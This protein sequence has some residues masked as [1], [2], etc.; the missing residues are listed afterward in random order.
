MRHKPKQPTPGIKQQ[1]FAN[2][3]QFAQ[4][5]AIRLGPWRI[6]QVNEFGRRFTPPRHA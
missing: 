6:S 5:R 3:A 4:K 1:P 2:N